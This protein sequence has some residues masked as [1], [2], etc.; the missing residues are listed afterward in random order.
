MRFVKWIVLAVGAVVSYKVYERLTKN[1]QTTKKSDKLDARQ[2]GFVDN[3]LNNIKGLF[4][5]NVPAQAAPP[6]S[7]GYGA[8]G[9]P[10]YA[11]GEQ[12]TNIPKDNQVPSFL[13]GA[14]GGVQ[15]QKMPGDVA[16]G[17]IGVAPAPGSGAYYAPDHNHKTNKAITSLTKKKSKLTNTQLVN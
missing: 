9:V 2:P 5:S 14:T 12:Y 15:D 1:N 6:Q 13:K 11:A 16:P 10:T 4:N 3:L 8:V 17:R 7:S